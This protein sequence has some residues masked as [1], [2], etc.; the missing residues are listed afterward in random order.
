MEEYER[1][2]GSLIFDITTRVCENKVESGSPDET[3]FHKQ[4]NKSNV[5]DTRFRNF[6]SYYLLAA[7]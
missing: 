7:L 2:E 4:L 5:Y 3:Y 1:N 6:A